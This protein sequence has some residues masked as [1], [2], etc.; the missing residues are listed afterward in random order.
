MIYAGQDGK[1]IG[2]TRLATIRDGLED[3][4]YL[5]M[6]KDA[7]GEEFVQELISKVVDPLKPTNHT[8]DGQVLE[9]Q[10]LAV[11]EALQAPQ[12]TRNKLSNVQSM[13]MQ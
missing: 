10:R 5:A 13:H 3:H 2:S 1:L 7:K 6:L 12:S 4:E 8:G 9:V 11:L